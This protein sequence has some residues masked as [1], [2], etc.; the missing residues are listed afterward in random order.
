M[1]YMN[2]YLLK[3]CFVLFL[4]L[5]SSYAFGTARTIRKPVAISNLELDENGFPIL[6]VALW[7]KQAGTKPKLF[8]FLLNTNYALTVVDVG[9]SSSLFISQPLPADL[10]GDGRFLSICLKRVGVGGMIRDGIPAARMTLRR[11][12]V[13][14]FQDEPVDG[15]LGMSFLQGTRFVLKTRER[16]LEWWPEGGLEGATYPVTYLEN[17]PCLTLTVAGKELDFEV[18]TCGIGGLGLP[19]RLLPRDGEDPVPARPGLEASLSDQAPGYLAKLVPEFL[20]GYQTG[21]L[22]AEVWAA[23]PVCFDFAGHAITIARE[24][25]PL[26]GPR[27]GFLPVAW[28]RRGASAKLVIAAVP[29]GSALA[30]AGCQIGDEILQ[31]GPYRGQA[32]KRR[33][34]IGLL[35]EGRPYPWILKRNGKVLTL[36][37]N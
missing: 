16:R 27:N 13:G 31:A 32:L 2:I 30:K 6:K 17:R 29:A 3:N 34:I 14:R 28:D 22:G 23:A 35:A 5:V 18:E 8:R 7:S 33:A 19:E 21:A 15:V 4:L 11:E 10:Q 25:E 9:I 36:S 24:A 1:A 12:E 20:Q 37:L 26:A